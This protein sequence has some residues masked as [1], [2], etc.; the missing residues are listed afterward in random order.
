MQPKLKQFLKYSFKIVTLNRFSAKTCSHVSH[1]MVAALRTKPATSAL[2]CMCK[3][4]KK[5]PAFREHLINKYDS[6]TVSFQGIH[7]S[8]CVF[9]ESCFPCDPPVVIGDLCVDTWFIF[10]GTALTPAHHTEQK[11]PT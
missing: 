5:A 9:D 10:P 3:E 6:G 8:F 4:K 2:A 7:Q 11:H 1:V